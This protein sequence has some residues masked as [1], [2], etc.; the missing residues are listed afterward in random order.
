MIWGSNISFEESSN[1][2]V[3]QTIATPAFTFQEIVFTCED[4]PSDNADQY[5]SITRSFGNLATIGVQNQD[6]TSH[7]IISPCHINMMDM[8]SFVTLFDINHLIGG[9]PSCYNHRTICASEAIVI[10]DIHFTSFTIEKDTLDFDFLKDGHYNS[11]IF[12]EYHNNFE[13]ITNIYYFIL[14]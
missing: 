9:D 11:S 6:V 5:N 7:E 1:L 4:I 13:K 10:T 12:I 2:F 14:I 3:F 8:E